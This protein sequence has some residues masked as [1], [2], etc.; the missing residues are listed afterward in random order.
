M[1]HQ[2]ILSAP[3]LRIV[4]HFL[5]EIL[6]FENM[7]LFKRRFIAEYEQQINFIQ[8][9]RFRYCTE[10]VKICIG[11]DLMKR[12]IN[13]RLSV[14]GILRESELFH[15]DFSAHTLLNRLQHCRQFGYDHLFS[16]KMHAIENKN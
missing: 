6:L 3:K 2:S 13:C 14:F 4:K 1:P 5:T 12:Y 15:S 10:I 8:F 16:F 9:G 11:N 7:T